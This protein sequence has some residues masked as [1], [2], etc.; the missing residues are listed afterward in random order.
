VSLPDVLTVTEAAR[1]LRV[2]RSTA[3]ELA[4]R[5][6]ATDGGEGLPVVRVGRLLR[7]P[8]VRLEGFIGG[9]LSELPAST[10]GPEP[11]PKSGPRTPRRLRAVPTDD[12]KQRPLPFTS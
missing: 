3:Y 4:E 5:Y 1:V 12:A 6:L 10:V 7:V 2:S 11:P 8:R 9:P